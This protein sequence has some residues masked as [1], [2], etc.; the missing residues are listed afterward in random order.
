MDSE[1]QSVANSDAASKATEKEE[2]CSVC[3]VV[4]IRP[5]ISNEL[6]EGCR[7][8]LDVDAEQ[9][10]VITA[11]PNEGHVVCRSLVMG[12]IFC[13]TESMGPAMPHRQRTCLEIAFSR[14]WICCSRDIMRRC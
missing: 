4:N 12:R 1:N 3:V 6:V 14:W 13:L 8:C 11:T 7:E 9:A 2:E 10:Q 5:L